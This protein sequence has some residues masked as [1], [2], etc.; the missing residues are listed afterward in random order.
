[1]LLGNLGQPT[2][3]WPKKL[4]KIVLGDRKPIRG[5]P[6][7]GLKPLNLKKIKEE[8]SQKIKHEATDDDLFSHLMYPEVFA[9][10]VKF[11]R[12]YSEVGV[13]PTPAFFYGLKPGEE[14]SVDIEAGK[15]L[16][17]KLI[18]IGDIDIDGRRTVTFELNGMTREATVTDRSVQ[19]KAKARPKGRPCRSV[20]SRRADSGVDYLYRGRASGA[21][22]AKGDKLL[23]LGSD[24]DAEH[25]L[26][27]WRRNG[28]RTP[29]LRKLGTRWKARTC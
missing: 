14:I 29:F 1:M 13:L 22:V 4:Q 5:R 20:S 26:C 8:Q 25:D 11:K 6:G 23:T 9:E 27:V 15:T 28:G 10:F 7:A 21:K 24:E 2:G 17:I 19:A 12:D 16:F 3:G 18:H